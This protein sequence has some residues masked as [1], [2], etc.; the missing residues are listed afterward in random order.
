MFFKPKDRSMTISGGVLTDYD[1]N[2]NK[3]GIVSV[4]DGVHTIGE[5][6]FRYQS[7]SAVYLPHGLVRIKAGAFN[8]CWHLERLNLPDGVRVIERSAFEAC[9]DL[10]SIYIPDGVTEIGF[11]A[12]A[13]CPN[14]RGISIPGSVKKIEGMLFDS[15]TSLKEIH[16]G[17]GIES[18]DGWAFRNCS[19][20]E[21][22]S[23]PTSVRYIADNGIFIRC[24]NLKHLDISV[25]FAHCISTLALPASCQVHYIMP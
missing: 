15:C 9:R 8:D 20:L 1:D 18:I 7:V 22:I 23:I 10:Q 11:R 2:Q 17:H 4:P 12:F 14:L 5:D 24:T 19:A 21:R 6:A 3:T 25:G 16:L 13:D